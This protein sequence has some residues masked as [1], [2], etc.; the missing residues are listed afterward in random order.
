MTSESAFAIA[1]DD[2]EKAINHEPDF[3]PTSAAMKVVPELV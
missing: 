1:L 3:T 2:R